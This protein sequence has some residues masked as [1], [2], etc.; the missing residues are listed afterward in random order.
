MKRISAV[1]CCIV[2]ICLLGGCGFF[3]DTTELLTPPEPTGVMH[4]VKQ[5]LNKT[6]GTDYTP[7][8]P[9]SG[10]KQSS[11]VLEDIDGDEKKEAFA[12]YSITDKEKKQI[13]FNLLVDYSKEYTSVFDFS[14]TA[15]SVEKVD[16]CDFDGDGKKEITVGFEIYGNTEKT[17]IS[18]K[19]QSGKLNELIRS[20]YTNF[21][22]NDLLS[23][24]KNQLIIQ[25]LNEK[26]LKNIA[27]LYAFDGKAFSKIS[28]CALDGKVT[29]V[30]KMFFSVLSNGNPAVYLDEIKGVGAITEV[31]LISKGKIVNPLLSSENETGKTIRSAGIPCTDIN[32][33]SIPEIPI[34]VDTSANDVNHISWCSF[35]GEKLTV[36][37]TAFVNVIDGYSLI[38][39]NR[40]VGKVKVTKN[41]DRR[42]RTVYYIDK[43]GE[44]PD[45]KI[46]SVRVV[47]KENAAKS[48]VVAEKN[49]EK[50]IIEY[51]TDLQ[52]LNFTKK[53]LIKMFRFNDF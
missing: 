35:N 33:D 21:L 53:D 2:I 25:T 27:S 4:S 48:Q 31:L 37:Q 19:Y 29:S 30:S 9:S 39:P 32:D 51:V 23:N 28:S 34:S 40:L 45:K 42:Q 3:S 22:C 44:K 47:S 46:L 24:G 41:S 16:F 8:Y 12:F 17:L 50:F 5:A 49:G 6:V 26:K 15:S 43:N 1:V 36:K 13:H 18:F 38:I 11:V 20:K 7:E 52:E 10:E 14:I